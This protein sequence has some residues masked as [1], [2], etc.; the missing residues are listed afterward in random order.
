MDNPYATDD[1]RNDRAIK[2]S[3]HVSLL[4]GADFEAIDLSATLIKALRALP[5]L[6][7]L[8]LEE[9]VRDIHNLQNRIMARA[10]QRAY[11]ARFLDA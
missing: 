2:P 10:A 8:D 1:Y 4:T 5:V 3:P 7:P 6:H 9:S 11:P